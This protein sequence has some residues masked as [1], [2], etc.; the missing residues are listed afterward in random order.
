MKLKSRNHV[1]NRFSYLHKDLEVFEDEAGK[2]IVQTNASIRKGETVAVFGGKVVPSSALSS[3]GQE[4]FALPIS[5]NLFLVNPIHDDGPDAV[6]LIRHSSEPNCGFQGQI[7]LIA[8][9]DIQAGEEITYDSYMLNG[10][11]LKQSDDFAESIRKRY[12]GNF[13]NFIQRQ[14]DEDSN[15]RV[16]PM[17]QEGAWGL[18]TSL[19]VIDCSGALIRDAD[20]IKRYVVELCELIDMKRFGETHVVHFGEDERVAGY[21]MFQLIETSCISAHFANDTNTAYIDIF[22]CKGYDPKV[23]AEFTRKF[24]EGK[25]MRIN[26]CNRF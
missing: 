16:F 14:I 21:S 19:D 25:G 13:A 10:A 9:R 2:A 8:L 11:V 22:S 6:H 20:A 17:F 1:V 3:L 5:E 12:N 24:F 23:A 15:L 26:V 7:E 4:V 18:L